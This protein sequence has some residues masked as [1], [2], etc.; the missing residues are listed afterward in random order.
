MY[1]PV[2][3]RHD[4]ND[5]LSK[6][7]QRSAGPVRTS[8]LSCITESHSCSFPTRAW[9]SAGAFCPLV[10]V[11]L[12]EAECSHPF[13]D[14]TSEAVPVRSVRARGKTA[15]GQIHSPRLHQ[16]RVWVLSQTHFSRTCRSTR[17]W[18]NEVRDERGS[19]TQQRNVRKNTSLIRAWHEVEVLWNSTSAFIREPLQPKKRGGKYIRFLTVKPYR[20]KMR[21]KANWRGR[22]LPRERPCR[23]VHRSIINWYFL[24][25]HQYKCS[26]R[27]LLKK[28]RTC[29][30]VFPLA[31]THQNVS[32]K[33]S[34]SVKKWWIVV[35][36]QSD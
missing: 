22:V 31:E 15:C 5:L 20:Q 14:G 10:Y 4:S 17:G 9:C 8:V 23:H 36:R 1:Q 13:E 7:H 11:L 29:A 19:V 3:E 26:K 30:G 33:Q 2:L 24:P 34:P 16:S 12:V 28:F 25:Q 21:L 32:V 35:D 6:N 18:K 27:V